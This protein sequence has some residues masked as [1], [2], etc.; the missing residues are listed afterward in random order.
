V[1]HD[2]HTSYPFSVFFSMEAKMAPRVMLLSKN[3]KVTKGDFVLNPLVHV[4]SQYAT[5]Y[6][7]FNFFFVIARL[8]KGSSTFLL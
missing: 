8:T 6:F 7:L 3:E 1:K 4:L 5:P 2:K